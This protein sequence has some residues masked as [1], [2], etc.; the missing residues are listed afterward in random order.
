M[1]QHQ[2]NRDLPYP[3]KSCE[4]ICSDVL[5]VRVTCRLPLA[6]VSTTFVPIGCCL[7]HSL[8]VMAAVWRLP[9]R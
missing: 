3:K 1:Q 2:A 7:F 8:D 5:V 6:R 4:P 9:I